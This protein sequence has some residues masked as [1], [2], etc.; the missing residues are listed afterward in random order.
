MT[1]P[2]PVEPATGVAL[3][4]AVLAATAVVDLAARG[5]DTAA[6]VAGL[7]D[8]TRPWTLAITGALVLAALIVD[9]VLLWLLVA[10]PARLGW[11]VRGW[12]VPIA[13][14]VLVVASVP[15]GTWWGAVAGVWHHRRLD[16][17]ARAGRPGR[18][19]DVIVDWTYAQAALR[20]AG[21]VATAA[22]RAAALLV[23]VGRL[24]RLAA[25]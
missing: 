2:R 12:A 19:G 17:A 11:M 7:V 20:F 23:A 8:P 24:R 1:D 6:V 5:L 3:A 21:G 10:A 25:R 4:L 14:A 18:L 13:L 22:V 16:A 9:G 15:V